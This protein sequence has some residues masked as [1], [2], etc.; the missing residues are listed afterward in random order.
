MNPTIGCIVPT[1]GRV[2][3]A[4]QLGT[5]LPQMVEGDQ[6]LVVGDGPQ[7]WAEQ[8]CR[9]LIGRGVR[10][11]EGPRTQCFGNAQRQAGLSSLADV[12]LV[13][14]GDDDDRFVQGSWV[15]MREA[16][17]AAPGALLLGQFVDR[18]GMVVWRDQTIR[19]GNV[20]TQCLCLPLTMA[21]RGT[22][23]NRY[24]GDFDYVQS[25]MALDPC[26]TV[27]WRPN[28]WQVCRG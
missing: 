14:F 1:M 26:P 19:Q 3:L 23:G 12:D 28:V 10:Y 7:P 18:H 25:L 8:F 13:C 6:V 27:V 22:W 24:E 5:I 11:L 21:Q 16:A 9:G 15:I 17:E 2:L 20:S 4:R